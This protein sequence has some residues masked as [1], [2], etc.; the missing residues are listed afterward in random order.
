M[1]TD[2]P[3]APLE[4]S[5]EPPEVLILEPRNSQQALEWLAVL[6]AAG[7]HPHVEYR[8]YR[9]QIVIAEPHIERARSEL[10]AFEQENR[11]WPP[12][13]S[14]PGDELLGISATSIAAGIF[15]VLFFGITGPSHLNS[16][17]FQV[18]AGDA[19]RVLSGDFWRIVTALTLHADLS[20]VLSNALCLGILGGMVC[21][22][23]GPG[24][25]WLAIV[26]SGMLGNLLS[27]WYYREYMVS[28]GAST[29]VFGCLGLL[30]AMRIVEYRRRGGPLSWR[31]IGMPM[32]LVL[33]VFGLTGISPQADVMAHL[34]GAVAG[35]LVGVPAAWLVSIREH[36]AW[37]LAAGLG[38]VAVI[39]GAWTLALSIG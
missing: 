19:A 27:D 39:V 7:I 31:G 22:R 35:L 36:Q 1:T 8:N 14:L 37:Q 34:F 26:G 24:A 5:S 16:E 30:A 29:S 9:W 11:Y 17:W 25:G 13:W 23:I 4:P 15:L 6:G 33:A 18:G 32:V 20:H 38:I 2:P 10:A 28:V 3:A 12:R 21:R